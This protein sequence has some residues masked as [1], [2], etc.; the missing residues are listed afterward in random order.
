MTDPNYAV[1]PHSLLSGLNGSVTSSGTYN[2]V[3][4]I[5]RCVDQNPEDFLIF[6]NKVSKNHRGHGVAQCGR[7]IKITT[8]CDHLCSLW[9]NLPYHN[10]ILGK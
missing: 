10:R 5:S 1:Y 8:L 9:F 4:G 2:W 3:F 7:K 6:R